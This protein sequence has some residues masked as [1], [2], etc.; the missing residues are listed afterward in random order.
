MSSSREIYII[1]VVSAWTSLCIWPASRS[2]R[3]R[4]TETDQEWG[5]SLKIHMAMESCIFPIHIKELFDF[6]YC[7]AIFYKYNGLVGLL[8]IRSALMDERVILWHFQVTYW[9]SPRSEERFW[10][11]YLLCHCF[12]CRLHFK[13]CTC[14]RN[15]PISGAVLPTGLLLSRRLRMPLLWLLGHVSEHFPRT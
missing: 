10:I 13:S 4:R 8:S 2:N 15:D 12:Y 1:I 11:S 7:C 9:Y 5:L 3:Q 6:F 14:L